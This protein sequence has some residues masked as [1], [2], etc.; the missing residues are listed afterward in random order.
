MEF[1]CSSRKASLLLF[2]LALEEAADLEIVYDP[3]CAFPFG[4]M[5]DFLP[6][7]FGKFLHLIFLGQRTRF[8]RIKGAQPLLACLQVERHGGSGSVTFGRHSG[9]YMEQ[10]K[11]FRSGEHLDPN[12]G[13]NCCKSTA[14]SS[15]ML[16][17]EV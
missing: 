9:A 4:S 5:Q 2:R 1:K 17:S 16:G 6:P 15:L 7:A 8:K 11:R 12:S 13:L 14:S 3:L 10:R